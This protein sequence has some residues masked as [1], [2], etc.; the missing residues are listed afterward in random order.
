VD[1]VTDTNA[2]LV[3]AIVVTRPGEGRPDRTPKTSTREFVAYFS[4]VDE[5]V[6]LLLKAN[7]ARHTGRHLRGAAEEAL[8]GDEDFNESNVMHSINGYVY[9]NLPGLETRRGERVR[10]YVLDLGTEVDLH[11]PTGTATPYSCKGCARTCPTCCPVTWSSRICDQTRGAPGCSTATSTTTS[12]RACKPS[13]V[14][15]NR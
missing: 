12:R 3:A 7:V 9:G 11:S 5:N 8:A 10:W 2:G 14:S 13:T 15:S 1:E 4:V 6:S